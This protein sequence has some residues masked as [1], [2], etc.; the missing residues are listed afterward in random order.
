MSCFPPHF[1]FSFFGRHSVPS[2]TLINC[3][4]SLGL[5]FSPLSA[6]LSFDGYLASELWQAFPPPPSSL[7]FSPPTEV[8]IGMRDWRSQLIDN[9]VL[10]PDNRSYSICR[11]VFLGGESH[12]HD[13]N[14]FINELETV[15]CLLIDR[16]PG[17][18][19]NS[20]KLLLHL[21]KFSFRY[22]ERRPCPQFYQ[23]VRNRPGKTNPAF[24]AHVWQRESFPTEC[25][26]KVKDKLIKISLIC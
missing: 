5:G 14:V 13:W 20:V 1:V 15:G 11:K 2:L 7:F 10:L 19:S 8:I 25:V 22:A 26:V 3:H 4:S 17:D 9:N 18:F 24:S 21:E 16:V 12:R 23:F 6:A